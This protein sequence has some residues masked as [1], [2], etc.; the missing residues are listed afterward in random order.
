[1]DVQGAVLVLALVF[2]N[3]IPV[4]RQNLMRHFRQLEMTFPPAR[5]VARLALRAL[6]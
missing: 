6:G 4:S 2:R 5:N 3:E 1:L